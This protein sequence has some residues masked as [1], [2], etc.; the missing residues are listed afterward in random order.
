MAQA[1]SVCAVA[2]VVVAVGWWSVRAGA[3]AWRPSPVGT[4][5]I[6]SAQREGRQ[7]R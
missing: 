4:R 1:E 3:G 5:R 7:R 2:I 6:G